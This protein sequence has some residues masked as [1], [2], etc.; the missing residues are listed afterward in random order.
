MLPLDG[1]CIPISKVI[2]TLQTFYPQVCKSKIT[3]ASEFCYKLCSDGEKKKKKSYLGPHSKLPI[4]DQ[5]KNAC[6]GSN[7]DSADQI[8]TSLRISHK[9]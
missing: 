7:L 8:G 4:P 6:M 1:F 2:S 3:C 5:W 9:Y